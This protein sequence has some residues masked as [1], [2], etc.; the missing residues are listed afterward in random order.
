MN[1]NTQA[2]GEPRL[3]SPLPALPPSEDTSSLPRP[4]WMPL[5]EVAQTWADFVRYACHAHAL[6]AVGSAFLALS[7]ELSAHTHYTQAYQGLWKCSSVMVAHTLREAIIDLREACQQWAGADL[8]LERF[9]NETRH[10]EEMLAT[11]HDLFGDIREQQSR[12]W[13]LLLRV[14]KE[15]RT[16][17]SEPLVVHCGHLSSSQAT[18]GEE[19]R[20]SP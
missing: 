8:W 18:A 17:G 11:I 14:Q 19:G 3:S 1:D 12:L 6:Q 2:P 4:E 20:V 15:Q 16:G 5:D 9:A 10:D 13:L 7:F